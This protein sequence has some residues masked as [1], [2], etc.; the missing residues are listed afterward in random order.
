[1]Q[2]L[3][4]LMPVGDEY[5]QQRL[6]SLC[7]KIN[8]KPFWR[9]YSTDLNVVVA[10]ARAELSS[11]ATPI[12]KSQPG[13]QASLLV[14]CTATSESEATSR[15]SGFLLDRRAMEEERLSRLGQRK[16]GLSPP[17]KLFNPAQGHCDAWQLGESVND[18][19][20]RLPPLST[21][22]V[23]CPWIWVHN[24]HPD[25][26]AQSTS[27][28]AEEFSRR[29]MDLLDQSLRVRQELQARFVYGSKA[30]MAKSL[31]QESKALQQRVTDLAAECGILS[32]KVGALFAE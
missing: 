12:T 3:C 10:P 2:S 30:V 13:Q 4:L 15:T 27:H 22:V 32:G 21:S 11:K 7:D 6:H 31:N 5:E 14:E 24:P 20:R 28:C 26:H 18:F 25:L 19:V 17:H 29:G 23:T 9:T 1:M 16:R 8:P